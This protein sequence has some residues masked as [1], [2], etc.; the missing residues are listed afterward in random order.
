LFESTLHYSL[1]NASHLLSVISQRLVNLFADPQLVKQ[2]GQL[3]RYRDHRS[4]L[5]IPFGPFAGIRNVHVKPNTTVGPCGR[6]SA[7]ESS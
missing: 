6:A 1:G 2:Y 4:F 3:P 5:G 7:R